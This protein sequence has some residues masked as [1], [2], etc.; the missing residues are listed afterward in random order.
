[1][2]VELGDEC[3]KYLTPGV[4]INPAYHFM[5]AFALLATYSDMTLDQK[6]QR[7]KQIESYL[8]KLNLW[9][10]H[11]PST[12]THMTDLLHA[13]LAWNDG[14]FSKSMIYFDRGIRSALENNFLQNA[15]IGAELAGKWLLQHGQNTSGQGYI[16]DSMEYY[17]AWGATGRVELLKTT[18]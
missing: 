4:F 9:S 11:C 5:H 13:G 17:K 6:V 7:K 16:D 14:H 10:Q 18:A 3:K 2:V 8:Y 15:A 12:F 1:R